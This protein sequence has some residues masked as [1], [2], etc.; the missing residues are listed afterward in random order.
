MTFKLPEPEYPHFWAECGGIE[1]QAGYTANQMHEAYKQ[2]L[3]DAAKVADET[4]AFFDG[5][6]DIHPLNQR[7]I[8]TAEGIATAIRA[9][10]KEQQ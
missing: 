6:T 3:E 4:V 1:T 7:E 8:D 10:I 5:A 9:L 2:G